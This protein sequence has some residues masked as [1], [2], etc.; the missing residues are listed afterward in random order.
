M[1]FLSTNAAK[2]TFINVSLKIVEGNEERRR[3][4]WSQPSWSFQH[5]LLHRKCKWDNTGWIWIHFSPGSDSSDTKVKKKNNDRKVNIFEC[6]MAK[7]KQNKNEMWNRDNPPASLPCIIL[8]ILC[9]KPYLHKTSSQRTSI[10]IVYTYF[11]FIIWSAALN[12]TFFTI[13]LFYLRLV[14]L[15]SISRSLSLPHSLCMLHFRCELV[16][17]GLIPIPILCKFVG[18][19]NWKQQIN[20]NEGNCYVQLYTIQ[21]LHTT[22]TQF[23]FELEN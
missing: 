16:W 19:Q 15:F 9:T 2:N 12:A 11:T 3:W 7:T 8:F 21:Q 17:A 20:R 10:H 4:R 5:N 23:Q 1:A 14:S 13:F 6:K 18:G 22:H